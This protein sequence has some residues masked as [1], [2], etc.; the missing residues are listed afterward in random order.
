[1]NGHLNYKGYAGS[2]E[3]SEDDAVFHGKVTGLKSLITFEGASVADLTADFHNAVNEYLA[4]CAETGK[5]PEK[6]FK[7]SFN[8]R[9]KADLHR[10][11][12]QAASARGI[13]LN[14][15]VEDAIRQ[16]VGR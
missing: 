16:A 3:F 5:Q 14:A 15:L 10:R 6:P 7:G 2:I 1:M 9:I 12:A 11:A 8:V 13:S 4:F